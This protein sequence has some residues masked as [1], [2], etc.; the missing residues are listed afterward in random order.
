[1]TPAGASAAVPD[2]TGSVAAYGGSPSENTTGSD[3]S[4]SL[5]DVSG[6]TGSSAA[7]AGAGPD[8]T[9][10][11]HSTQV[12]E[13]PSTP[14]AIHPLTV[15][16]GATSI[17]I[18][19]PWSQQ[20]WM[21]TSAW[22]AQSAFPANPSTGTTYVYGHACDHY[23]CPFTQ[24]A[25][26]DSGGYTVAPGDLVSVGLSTGTLSE[27]VCAVGSSSKSAARLSVPDC[28]VASIDLVIVTCQRD[29]DGS[30]TQNIVVAATL[31]P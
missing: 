20:D 27:R 31:E 22:I 23:R 25:K 7:G 14:A 17:S 10:Q 30:S 2:G 19:E 9:I 3:R 5:P 16:A 29:D 13:I 12:G 15:P 6:P 11:L 18:P 21:N 4:G 26:R 24:V 28:G 8:F 1:M